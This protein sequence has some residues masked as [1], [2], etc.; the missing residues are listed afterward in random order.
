MGSYIFGVDVA[1]LRDGIRGKS[2]G[3]KEHRWDQY[4]FRGR[5][6]GKK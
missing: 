4:S 3:L 1:R 6:A 2:L 5:K